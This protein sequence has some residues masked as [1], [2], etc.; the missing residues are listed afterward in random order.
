MLIVLLVHFTIATNETFCQDSNLTKVENDNNFK[1][2]TFHSRGSFIDNGAIIC[3]DVKIVG[4][5]VNAFFRLVKLDEKTG[6]FNSNF[7]KGR[8]YKNKAEVVC[9]KFKIDKYNPKGW[10]SYSANKVDSFDNK[11]ILK[12]NAKVFTIKYEEYIEADE[13]I[14]DLVA[15]LL[16]YMKDK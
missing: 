4:N 10:I 12:G 5:G 16:D 6:E 7:V 9:T 1:I 14:I 13:I 11:I 2:I 8:F 15:H 3:R